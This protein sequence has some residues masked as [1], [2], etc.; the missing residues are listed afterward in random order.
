MKEGHASRTAEYMALFRALESSRP[1]G[2][3]LF[4]DPLARHFLSPPLALVARLSAV[5]G[6]RKLLSWFI[7]HRWPGARSSAVAR[8]RF[9]DDAVIACL[10]AHIEQVV[11]LGAGFDSRAYRLHALKMVAVFEVDHPDTLKTK[12]GMLDRA[13]SGLPERVRFV[14]TDFN[15][16]QLEQAMAA[17]GYRNSVPT[18]FLWEGVTNYLTEAAVDAT[19]RWCSRAAPGSQLVFTYVHRAVLDDPRSFFGTEKL[20]ATL[21]AS[22][23]K[24]TF[25]IDPA[26]VSDFLAQR[27]LTLERDLG[28]EDYR[29]LYFKAAARGMRGY[30]FYRIVVARV[31]ERAVQPQ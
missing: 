23:E 28:A 29:R 13:L 6:I 18:L 12:R 30:E 10:Q 15:Q 16:R 11:I 14:P 24:W 8:T 17:A 7:D 26:A 27:G 31:P 19:L 9:I 22:G 5:P 20:L 4:E 1:P 25:G 3:R 21:A 2:R